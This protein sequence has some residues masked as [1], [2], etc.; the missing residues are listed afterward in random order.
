MKQANSTSYSGFS[1]GTG[2]GLWLFFLFCFIFLGYSIPL[3]I[4]LGAAG[5]LASALVLGWW[6]TK[7][8]P[9][10]L[11]PIISEEPEELEDMPPKVSGLRLAHQRDVKARNRS[12]GLFKPFSRFFTR[13][14]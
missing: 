5:G 4:L 2:L 12:Q 1:T 7:D 13:D 11:K 3:S 9:D 6:K 14:K 8:N 10:D